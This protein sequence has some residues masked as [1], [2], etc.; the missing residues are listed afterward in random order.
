M[1]NENAKTKG[2]ANVVINEGMTLEMLVNFLN[3]LNRRLC[4]LEDNIRIRLDDNQ[5]SMSITDFYLLNEQAEEEKEN[6]LA[7]IKFEEKRLNQENTNS[8][9]GN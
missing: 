1:E 5:E 8:E 6:K 2:W 7:D 3:V 9:L 4:F